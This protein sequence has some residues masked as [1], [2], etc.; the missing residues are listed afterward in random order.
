[1]MYLRGLVGLLVI[2]DEKKKIKRFNFIYI[3]NI[4]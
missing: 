2:P 4:S 1:M 3:G